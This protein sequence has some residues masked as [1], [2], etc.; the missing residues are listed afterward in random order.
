[1]RWKVRQRKVL[2]LKRGWPRLEAFW[3][4]VRARLNHLETRL[5]EEIGGLRREMSAEIG[6]LRQEMHQEISGLRPG[7]L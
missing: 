6:G 5:G 7:D 2:L 3:R 1:M 4:E